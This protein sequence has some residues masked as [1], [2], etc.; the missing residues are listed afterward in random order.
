[1]TF[2]AATNSFSFTMPENIEYGTV[3][4]D[5]NHSFGGT[6]IDISIGGDDYL[7]FE[8]TEYTPGK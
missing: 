6:I 1:M 4:S 5:I 8:M 7:Q 2:D 3:I